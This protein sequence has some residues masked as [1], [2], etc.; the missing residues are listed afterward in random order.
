MES[1][2]RSGLRVTSQPL[3]C[4]QGANTALPALCALLKEAPVS[5]VVATPDLLAT[6][7]KDLAA[8][9]SA[10]SAA[11]AAAAHSTTSSL[12]AGADEVSTRIAAVF[13]A[14]GLKYQAVEPQGA[15]FNPAIRARFGGKHERISDHRDRQRRTS[16]WNT[17]TAPARTLLRRRD[18]TAPPRRPLAVPTTRSRSFDG[19]P[20]GG[21]GGA[22][23]GIRFAS[24]RSGRQ[25]RIT[26]PVPGRCS[27]QNSPARPPSV[28]QYSLRR[29]PW[30]K[31]RVE[32]CRV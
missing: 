12:A 28:G 29:L 26:S 14:H 3:I 2:A 16:L 20:D 8:M 1:R 11:N 15:Q 23:A 22:A 21:T 25:A 19:A 24:A 18:E 13:G 5:Y 17:V 27:L 4:V 30:T 6:A 10:V 32:S 9:G 31:F 7:A